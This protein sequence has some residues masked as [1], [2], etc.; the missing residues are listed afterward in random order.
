MV[1]ILN[2]VQYWQIDLMRLSHWNTCDD[3]FL[4]F[5]GKKIIDM[6]CRGLNYTV[7]EVPSCTKWGKARGTNRFIRYGVEDQRNV[8]FI[9]SQ[10]LSISGFAK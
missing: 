4:E 8:G 9:H 1:K 3:V 7:D 2:E 5:A 10:K 6:I